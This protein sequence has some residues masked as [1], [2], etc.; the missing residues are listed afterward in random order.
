MNVLKNSQ[1]VI[2]RHDVN[3]EKCRYRKKTKNAKN[4]DLEK[5]LKLAKK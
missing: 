1:L 2:R 5:I 3:L 4:G